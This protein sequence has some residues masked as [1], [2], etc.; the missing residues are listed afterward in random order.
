MQ[1]REVTLMDLLD[2]RENRVMH[3]KELLE[4]YEGVIISMTLNIPGSIK[5]KPE[6]RRAL[7]EGMKRVKDALILEKGCNVILFSEIRELVTGPE[8]YICVKEADPLDI[9]KITV[10]VEEADLLGRLLDIDVIMDNGG[11]SRSS[12][13][14]GPRKCLICSQDAKVCARSRS[15]DMEQLLKKIDEIIAESGI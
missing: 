11:I 1:N 7:K 5:D 3:Q 4:K 13:G 2:S 15:H 12:L 8:G 10:A 9:K 6:Y 14:A